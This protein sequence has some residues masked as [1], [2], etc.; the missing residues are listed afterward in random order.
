MGVSTDFDN[1]SWECLRSSSKGADLKLSLAHE[2]GQ[3]EDV[4]SSGCKQGQPS[5]AAYVYI[6]LVSLGKLRFRPGKTLQ[7]FDAVLWITDCISLIIPVSLLGWDGSDQWI[8]GLADGSEI[9]DQMST[10]LLRCGIHDQQP[11]GPC[12]QALH[13]DLRQVPLG[14]AGVPVISS[15]APPGRTTTPK[16]VQ[17][18]GLPFLRRPQIAIASSSFM[19]NESDSKSFQSLSLEH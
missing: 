10:R 19:K 6:L 3:Q 9:N 4:W 8:L 18:F 7:N 5:L 13:S 16:T 11:L 2:G 1:P 14:R 17:G 12:G 15:M